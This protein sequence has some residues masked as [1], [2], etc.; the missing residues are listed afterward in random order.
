L[1]ENDQ[2]AGYIIPPPPPKPN[3][4]SSREKLQ[5]LGDCEANVTKEEFAKMKQ[6]LEA[7]YLAIFKKTVAMHEIFLQRLAAHEKFREDNN[8]KIFLEYEN[9]LAV[10]GKTKREKIAGSI[11]NIGKSLTDFVITSSQVA[12][13]NSLSNIAGSVSGTFAQNNS[14]LYNNGPSYNQAENISRTNNDDN[15]ILGKKSEIKDNR[16]TDN[17]AAGR[18]STNDIS[19]A[20]VSDGDTGTTGDTLDNRIDEQYF[21]K[22]R[23]FLALYHNSIR[24]TAI[25]ADRMTQS[26]KSVADSY[27]HIAQQLIKLASI[28]VIP[29]TS[30]TVDTSHSVACPLPSLTLPSSSNIRS[31][32]TLDERNDFSAGENFK[33]NTEI[34][35]RSQG[36]LEL[37]NDDRR[38]LD[39]ELNSNDTSFYNPNDRKQGDSLSNDG[40]NIKNFSASN[41]AIDQTSEGLKKILLNV[42]DYLEKARKIETRLA[43]DED[44]KLTDTFLYYKRDTVAA[45]DLLMRR[46]R[47][48]SE[49]ENATKNL[50]KARLKGRT[51]MQYA[52]VIQKQAKENFL[53]ISSL[54][55]QELIDYKKRRVASFREAFTDIAELEIKHLKTHAKSIVNCLNT[56]RGLPSTQAEPV[57]STSSQQ[58]S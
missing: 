54:A 8:F 20:S 57:A 1:C 3:F 32:R 42:S 2:Y 43:S 22:E 39:Q 21:E 56:C 36:R 50:E 13:S 14:D 37:L 51:A 23:L 35:S 11:Q 15:G 25:C 19:S 31:D 10:R 30:Q 26:H 47:F 27:L 41:C 45:Q 29:I 24:E 34:S 58:P 18:S 53:S 16:N 5:R 48:M 6:E 33:S 46:L 4:D 12:S 49:Y 17:Q 28:E 9:E 44:L 7:E 55:K 40:A 52:D 38:G